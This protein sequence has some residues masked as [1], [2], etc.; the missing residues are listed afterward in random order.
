[1]DRADSLRAVIAPGR[2]ADSPLYVR[3]LGGGGEPRM[4]EG[5]PALAAE[6][7]A[8]VGRWIDGGAP[9]LAAIAGDGG[10]NDGPG[11]AGR[12]PGQHWAYRPL[13][14]PPV[15]AGADQN[16][17]DAFLQAEQARAGLRPAPQAGPETLIRRVTLDLTGLPPTPAEIEAFLSDAAPGACGRLVDRLLGAPAFGERW[18]V[19]WLDAAR[20]A[21]SNGYEKDGA[22][23]VWPYRDWVVAALNADMPFD[24]F[25]L[26]Q[27][28]GDLLPAATA[29]QRI[30]TGFHRNTMLNEEARRRSRR[31]ALGTAGGPGRHHRHGLA[32]AAR[33]AAPSAT[34]TSTIRSASAT[35]TGC[36][37]SSRRRRSGRRRCRRRRR[38]PGW[39]RW[40]RRS[41]GCSGCWTPGRRRWA[42]RRRAGRRACVT[43]SGLTCRWGAWRSRARRGR[44][45]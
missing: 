44:C 2:R 27:I 42:R 24:R 8:L 41:P 29:A 30:A 6:E 28:A 18:A 34:T 43:T 7:I 35:S 39:R 40:I 38:R 12:D 22:R 45:A 32:R 1:M 21:D 19:P 37:P 4:P 33:S 14:R 26:E 10:Q 11:G 17:I 5:K 13:A 3:L 31:G 25:T 23:P 20:Y 9:G 16:P 15:P 36:W